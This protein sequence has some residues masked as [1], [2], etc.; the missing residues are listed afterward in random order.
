[1]NLVPSITMTLAI[2]LAGR[3]RAM[4]PVRCPRR[5][6]SGWRFVLPAPGDPFEHAPFRA[7]VLAREKPE[8]LVEKVAYRGDPARRRYAQIRFG[9]PGSIRVTVVLDEV[10]PGEA[11][12]YV[13][14]DRNRR[15]DDRDRVAAAPPRT[16]RRRRPSRADLAAA[17]RRGDGR[18]GRDEEGPPRG[19]VPP[20]RQRPD[21]RLRRG[22][23]P[24]GDHRARR[25]GRPAGK[26][27]RGRASRSTATAT[28]RSPTRRTA[29]GST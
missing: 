18:Q 21:A 1:M 14:A 2:A 23:L 16:A 9:S 12:L 4:I 29:S 20:G 8:D 26:P 25:R 22:R 3:R 17:A 27:P 15:I 19:G 7:L 11:D 10:G 24:R 5:A 6:S 13:D 28:A